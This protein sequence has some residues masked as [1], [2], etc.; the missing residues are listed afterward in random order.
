MLIKKKKLYGLKRNGQIVKIIK[1]NTFDTQGKESV[2][3]IGKNK[4]KY[5]AYASDF[6]DMGTS[7]KKLKEKYKIIM[8]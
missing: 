7:K 4:R 1:N 2:T 6:L 5:W 8:G 3:Y